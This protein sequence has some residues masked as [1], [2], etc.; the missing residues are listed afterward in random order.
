[1]QTLLPKSA[2][3][4]K[5]LCGI[6]RGWLKRRIQEGCVIA[7]TRY[8]YTD[9]Y[10][11]DAAVDFQ[12]HNEYT[13][14]LLAVTS[15]HPQGVMTFQEEDF[16]GRGGMCWYDNEDGTIHFSRYQAECIEM[17]VLDKPVQD[18]ERLRDEV[19]AKDAEQIRFWEQ[20]KQQLGY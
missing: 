5:R 16:R 15:N 19:A 17:V 8:R 9:D 13:P 18:F 6:N 14:V 2:D 3:P 11:W 10:A 4:T 1:M 7:K 20:R 12:K